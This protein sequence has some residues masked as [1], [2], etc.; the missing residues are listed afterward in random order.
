MRVLIT[1]G[2]GYLGRAVVR[3]LAAAGHDACVFARRAS[4]AGLPG[5]AIDGD[6]RDAGTVGR[7]M[8]GCDGVIH[9]AALVSIWRRRPADFDEVNVGGLRHVIEAATR[10]GIDRIVYTS[11]FLALPPTGHTDHL[12]A[13]DYQ[14]TKIAADALAEEAVR[15]GA[16]IVR[17]YPGVVYGPGADTEGNLVGRLIRDHLAGRLPGIVGGDHLWSFAYVEDVAA[18]HVAA[19]ER[20]ARGARYRLGGEN[21]PQ[22]RVFEIVERLTGRRMPRELPVSLARI[23]GRAEEW[24]VRLTGGQPLITTGAVRIFEHDWSFD[25]NLAERELGYHITPLAEGV[26]RTLAAL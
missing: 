21:A 16:P 15:A 8:A 17:T 24:R 25:S 5:T 11:S 23:A 6:V 12:R 1:G 14:R 9:M 19:I 18:A 7:A 26:E 3:A 20:G 22:R 2:T 13:N 10:A 4:M